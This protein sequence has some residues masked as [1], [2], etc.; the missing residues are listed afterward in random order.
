ML[1]YFGV[2]FCEIGGGMVEVVVG[3]GWR[4]LIGLVYG[5]CSGR[6]AMVVPSLVLRGR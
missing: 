2:D 3:G 4:W 5:V 6:V 1:T